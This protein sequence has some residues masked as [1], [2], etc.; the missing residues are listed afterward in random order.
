MII[1][2]QVKLSLETQISFYYFFKKKNHILEKHINNLEV[3]HPPLMNIDLYILG[4][5]Y[6]FSN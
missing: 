6:Y 3:M 2:C 4:I 5:T 1:I